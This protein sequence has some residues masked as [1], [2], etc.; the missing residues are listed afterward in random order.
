M[1]QRDGSEDEDLG[2][3]ADNSCAFRSRGHDILNLYAMCTHTIK[4]KENLK[5]G[6]DSNYTGVFVCA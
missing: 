4:N 2:Q 6:D 5:G 3:E 1:N